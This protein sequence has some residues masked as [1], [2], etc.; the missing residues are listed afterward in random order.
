V[1]SKLRDSGLEKDTLV[2]FF[3]DNGGPTM[4]GTALNASRNEPLRG[5]KRTT[6]EGGVKVPFLV[7]WP[8]RVPAGRVYKNPVIQLDVVPTALAAA[9]APAPA[10]AKLDGVNLLPYLTGEDAGRPHDKLYWRFGQQMAIRDGDWKLVRYDP[11]VDGETGKA[12]P[13]R[14]YHLARDIGENNDLFASQPE[15]AKE[16]QAE[17]DQ[18][19][20][21]NIPP[22]WGDNVNIKRGQAAG[23]RAK[24]AA[25]RKSKSNSAGQ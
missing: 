24:A 3:S 7:K 10:D 18:W 12:T 9:E 15:K 23:V 8:G 11:V 13:P 19:N 14:L 16:L 5:S 20:E 22:L 21:L 17:W 4:K 6:L 25:I 1:I 2:F